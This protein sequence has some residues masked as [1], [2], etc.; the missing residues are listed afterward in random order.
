M[1]ARQSCR[2]PLTQHT[3]VGEQPSMDS[4][5]RE[6]ANRFFMLESRVNIGDSEGLS[7]N[8]HAKAHVARSVVDRSA[9]HLLRL[10]AVA[11]ASTKVMKPIAPF[12]DSL[13]MVENENS[14]RKHTLAP[15]REFLLGITIIRST[16]RRLCTRFRATR[17]ILVWIAGIFQNQAH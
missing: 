11:S 14:K 15:S 5:P 7:R 2:R 3:N 13:M 17:G 9:D 16:R 1:I 8:P 12:R 10:K 4:R 6:N